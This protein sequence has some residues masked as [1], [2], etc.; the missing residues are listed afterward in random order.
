MRNLI[1]ISL[2][3]ISTV[4]CKKE[5]GSEP[6][7]DSYESEIS[8]YRLDKDES[9]KNGYLQL[10]GLFKFTKDSA[11]FGNTPNAD[12]NLNISE[13]PEHLGTFVRV[14]DGF[15]FTTLY[16]V[17]MS[18]NDEESLR[19]I[20]TTLNKDGNSIK[21]R[22]DRLRWQIITRS[23][24]QYLRVWDTKNPAIEAFKGFKFFPINNEFI[25]EGDFNYY[26]DA[27]EASVKSQLGVKANTTFIGNVSFQ[28]QGK[29]HNLEVGQDGFLMVADETTGEETYGGGRYV[30][31]DLPEE[32][33]KV[34]IDFNKL[35][36]PPCSF[37]EFTTCLYPPSSNFL[38]FAVNAGEKI[39]SNTVN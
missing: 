36:N 1:L 10:A 35:Y 37:S 31:L 20:A 12:F 11:S 22:Y 2:I 25:F 29:Q 30:Y 13:L 39:E 15:H 28:F 27:K 33:S 14:T 7:S 5:A 17:I 8:K 19:N 23:R 38:P 4:S 3:V 34:T 32:D 9:R 24:N 26:T 16:D 21:M 6:I 18:G